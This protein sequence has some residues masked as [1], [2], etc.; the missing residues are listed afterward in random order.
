MAS[1]PSAKSKQEESDL[2]MAHLEMCLQEFDSVYGNAKAHL[3]ELLRYFGCDQGFRCKTC[4]SAELENI[5]SNRAGICTLCKDQTWYTAGTFFHRIRKPRAWLF[6]IWLMGTG[7]SFNAC[8]LI[9]AIRDSSLNRFGYHQKSVD[10]YLCGHEARLSYN[11][12]I[13]CTLSCSRLQTQ[14][15]NAGGRTPYLR[16]GRD[17]RIFQAINVE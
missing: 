17:G 11:R 15:K 4:G 16:A 8:D 7:E 12:N 14:S 3:V 13:L 9:K 5:S 10:S 6:T 2:K 1:K